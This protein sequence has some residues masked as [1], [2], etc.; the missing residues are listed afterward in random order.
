MNGKHNRDDGKNL[1]KNASEEM[2][3]EGERTK[4]AEQQKKK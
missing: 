4:D 1:E 2:P 3:R